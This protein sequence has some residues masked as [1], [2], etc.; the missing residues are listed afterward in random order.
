[1]GR[2]AG[3]LASGARRH[4]FAMLI[5]TPL[6]VLLASAVKSSAQ[7]NAAQH[8]PKAF[9]LIITPRSPKFPNAFVTHA[10]R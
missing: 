5:A 9:S 3:Q 6:V 4:Y 7:S 10:R 1:M 2:D 8:K